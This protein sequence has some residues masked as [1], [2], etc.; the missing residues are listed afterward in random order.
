MGTTPENVMVGTFAV[1]PE[2]LSPHND[3]ID[4]ADN[5][6]ASTLSCVCFEI[7]N[8]IAFVLLALALFTTWSLRKLRADPKPL[9]HYYYDCERWALSLVFETLEWGTRD[10]SRPLNGKQFSIL[11]RIPASPVDVW[12]PHKFTWI[13][14]WKR[15]HPIDSYVDE[16]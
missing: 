4:I 8:N 10:V 6:I 9:Y 2:T 11:P 13:Q 5:I 1:F 7:L 14:F 12:L 16:I 3:A 15:K